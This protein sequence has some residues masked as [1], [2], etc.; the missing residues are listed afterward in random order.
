M[1]FQILFLCN[2]VRLKTWGQDFFVWKVKIDH[3][4]NAM[5][6]TKYIEDLIILNTL[7]WIEDT[8]LATFVYNCYC[9]ISISKAL[10]SLGGINKKKIM[11][12][13]LFYIFQRLLNYLDF[14]IFLMFKR[15]IFYLNFVIFTFFYFY[16]F[17]VHKIAF[18]A[19]LYR[20]RIFPFI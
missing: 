12:E 19:I 1:Y 6:E 8:N 3:V 13:N 16:L 15:S 20:N 17:Y 10:F 14:F 4:Y 9:Y 5:F 7:F 2:F 11:Y 18:L